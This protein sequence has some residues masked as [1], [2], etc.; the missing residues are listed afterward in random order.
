M[1]LGDDIAER[2]LYVRHLN[3]LARLNPTVHRVLFSLNSTFAARHSLAVSLSSFHSLQSAV[4]ASFF[5]VG[6]GRRCETTTHT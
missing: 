3:H 6:V 4:I 1:L 2:H 5:S